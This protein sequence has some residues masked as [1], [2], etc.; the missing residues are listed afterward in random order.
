MR[1]VV[2]TFMRLWF[3]TFVLTNNLYSELLR[4]AYVIY[5]L[6]WL[7]NIFLG[8]LME[9]IYTSPRQPTVAAGPRP[10]DA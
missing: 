3:F 10:L 7:Q 9:I 2:T 6:T 5:T 4:K 1:S 8:Q